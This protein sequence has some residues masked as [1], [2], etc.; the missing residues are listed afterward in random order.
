MEER[1]EA[2]DGSQPTG[3][4][5]ASIPLDWRAACRYQ[6]WMHA[7]VLA[8][9]C[10]L[11]PLRPADRSMD[12]L[13]DALTRSDHSPPVC[14]SVCLSASLLPS[15]A[16]RPPSAAAGCDQ[17]VH[18]Q[19]DT[20]AESEHD[21]RNR[22]AM[23]ACER[24]RLHGSIRLIW[25]RSSRVSSRVVSLCVV[26]SFGV[27]PCEGGL[28]GEAESASQAMEEAVSNTQSDQAIDTCARGQPSTVRSGLRVLIRPHPVLV[29]ASVPIPA[30]LCCRIR[31]CTA[32]RRR[33]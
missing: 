23:Q 15:A 12:G 11:D 25:R 24:A 13:A 16:R 20:R 8:A 28:V 17:Q 5:A 33:G 32:S 1:G 19:N 27:Q 9:A 30:G 6:T 22:R 29:S 7:C 2:R 4:L 31:R 21:T 26:V 10:R 3:G 14:L 18:T